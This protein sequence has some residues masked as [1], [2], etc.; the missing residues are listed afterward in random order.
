MRS[1]ARV[2]YGACMIE[3]GDPPHVLIDV[4]GVAL[5]ITVRR[6]PRARR[7]SLRTDPVAGGVVL[8]LPRRA[9]LSAGIGFARSQA[10]WIRGRLAQLPPP[11]PFAPGATL[12][13]LGER[14]AIVHEPGRR[15]PTRRSG[16]TLLVHGDEAFVAR[17]VRDWL[18][19]LARSELAAR[20]L[21]CAALIGRDIESIRIA[22]TRSRWGSCA[23]GGRLSFCWR[24]VLAP[25]QIV[26]Y[27]V[28]HEV[29]HLRHLDHSQRFWQVVEQLTPHRAEAQL[30]L[31][32]HGARLLRAGS[33]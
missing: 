26:D 2:G 5:A 9:S 27:V 3:T 7:V 18:R 30:W 16:H 13:I 31:R 32:R 19:S 12:E 14:V 33:V 10:R 15:G 8:V 17:R 11:T 22:D 28:A 1:R 23:P 20:A 29:A 24:L 21:R 25:P 6:H 4:D